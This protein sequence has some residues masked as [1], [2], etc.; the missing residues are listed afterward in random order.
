M[1]Y[2]ERTSLFLLPLLRSP[3]DVCWKRSFLVRPSWDTAL[4]Y[5]EDLTDAVGGGAFVQMGDWQA[6]GEKIAALCRN[7]AELVELIGK[8]AEN[9]KRFKDEAVFRERSDLIRRHS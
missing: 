3:P 5:A 1:S 7:R 9:G 2:G 6:L 4:P 8:A